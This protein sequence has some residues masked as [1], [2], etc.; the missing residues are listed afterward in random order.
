MP[1]I[2]EGL[3][4]D[5]HD[6]RDKYQVGQSIVCPHNFIVNKNGYVYKES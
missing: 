3:L 4:V 6:A 1:I 5:T 2:K